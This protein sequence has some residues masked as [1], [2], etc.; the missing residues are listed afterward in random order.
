M[1]P[2]PRKPKDPLQFP[3]TTEINT[4]EASNLGAA[5][6]D[7]KAMAHELAEALERPSGDDG[8]FTGPY[9]GIDRSVYETMVP[10]PNGPTVADTITEADDPAQSH[11]VHLDKYAEATAEGQDNSEALP[12]LDVPQPPSQ[13]TVEVLEED[14]ERLMALLTSVE[15][16]RG[17]YTSAKEEASRAKKALETTQ[18]ALERALDRIRAGKEA[19]QEPRLPF[20]A[21]AGIPEP[22]PEGLPYDGIHQSDVAQPEPTFPMGF[23]TPEMGAEPGEIRRLRVAQTSAWLIERGWKHCDPEHCERYSDDELDKLLAWSRG[24]TDIPDID[25]LTTAE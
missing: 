12:S 4:P 8:A 7:G 9:L 10:S 17:E 24:D 13:A 22:S 19:N 3:P 2:R 20:D 21:P 5:V 25:G 1:S 18:E 6:V 16:A 23:V 15:N 14:W 11:D